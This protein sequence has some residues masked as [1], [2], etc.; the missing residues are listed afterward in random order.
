MGKF[1]M[2][3]QNILPVSG[4]CRHFHTSGFRMMTA[5]TMLITIVKALKEKKVEISKCPLWVF[6]VSDTGPK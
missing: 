5:A 3:F 4:G 1:F 6:I 2:C